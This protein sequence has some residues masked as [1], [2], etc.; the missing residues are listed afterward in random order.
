M[1]AKYDIDGHYS[2]FVH[3]ANCANPRES[4]K[5]VPSISLQDNEELVSFDVSALFTSIPVD[6]ALDVINQLIIQHQTDINISVVFISELV[7]CMQLTR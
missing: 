2:R 6:Q 5:E 1:W 7:G 4:S 3:K